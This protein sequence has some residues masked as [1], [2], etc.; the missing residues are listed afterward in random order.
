MGRR[1][2][3]LRTAPQQATKPIGTFLGLNKALVIQENEWADMKNMSSD[4][5]PAIG[6]RKGRGAVERTLTKPNGLFYKNGLSYVDGTEWYY[7]DEK[8]ADVEDSQKTIVGMGAYMIMFPDKLR[9]N[10]ATGELEALEACWEQAAA[11]SFEQTTS[12]ST[13]VKVSCTGI[14]TLFSAFDGVEI[15]G[16]TKDEL[17]GSK[18]I[19]EIA[20]D[21]IVIIGD[22]PEKFTQ[23]TGLRITRTVPD[24]DYVCESENRLWGCSSANHEIYASKLGDAANWQ[25]FEGISTDAYA[26]TVGSDGDF[27][28][29]ISH[30]GYVLFFKEETI[31]KVMGNK[32]SNYQV[33]TAYPVRGAARGMERTLCVVNETLFYASRDNVCSYDGAQPEAVGD[34]V[35]DL[36]FREGVAAHWNGKYYASLRSESDGWGI[37]VYDQMR[38]LWHKEDEKHLL[39]MVYGNGKLYCIGEDGALYTIAGGTEEYL[40]WMLESGDLIEGSVDYKHVKKLQFHLRM[41]AEAEVNVLMQYDSGQGWERVMTYRARSYRTHTMC[42][43]PR[44]CQKY[45]FRLEGFGDVQL[46]A[47]T[48]CIG[49]G[50]DIHG[51]V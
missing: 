7:K 29:C 41:A 1:L 35:K 14:G 19:Q 37:Y 11:A 2:P 33:T 23:Q 34:A 17:N 13:T 40:P 49:Q 51:S 27:T 12:G 38:R 4:C 3:Y 16:C 5:Y 8:I 15:S 45:R 32:P 39:Y 43:V 24:M 9:Y 42:V 6:T 21:Y 18:I 26:V 48:R 36:K 50:S 44:R 25:A 10:T 22:L 31:H 47:M 46:I 28:G 20:E 30:L